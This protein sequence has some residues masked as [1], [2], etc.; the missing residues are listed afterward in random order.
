MKKTVS[1]L[2]SFVLV[3]MMVVSAVS[4]RSYAM[5]DEDLFEV[6]DS[7]IEVFKE[8]PDGD[9]DCLLPESQTIEDQ[10]VYDFQDD[11][12]EYADNVDPLYAASDHAADDAIN[13]AASK[14][15]QAI[16]LDGNGAWCVD[17][18]VAYQDYLGVGR[19]WG[20]GRDYA[21]NAL[22]SGWSR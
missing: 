2:I 19:V 22:P 20:N 17:L 11:P 12:N 7:D 5:T 10:P 3:L 4:I 16:D 6:I 13:W 14:I 8:S 18:I 9:T 1:R 21:W 15:G